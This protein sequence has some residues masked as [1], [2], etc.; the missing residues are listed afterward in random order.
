LALFIIRG[1]YD[2]TV[3][4]FIIQHLIGYDNTAP[5]KWSLKVCSLSK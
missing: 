3:T 4:G 5:W 2:V 1:R